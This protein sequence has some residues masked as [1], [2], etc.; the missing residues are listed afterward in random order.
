MTNFS[1][2]I[3]Q[4]KIAKNWQNKQNVIVSCHYCL[5]ASMTGR[6]EQHSF[7]GI[8]DLELDLSNFVEFENVTEQMAID[9]VQQQINPAFLQNVKQELEGRFQQQVVEFEVVENPWN[10]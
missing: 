4:V 7:D 2:S 8:Q 9:W 10:K 3:Q 5:T 1:W 6:N